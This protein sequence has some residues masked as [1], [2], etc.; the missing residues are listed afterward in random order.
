MERGGQETTHKTKYKERRIYHFFRGRSSFLF[1]YR[2]QNHVLW[3]R[4]YINLLTELQNY[5]RKFHTTGLV[6]NPKVC[7]VS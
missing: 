6:W 4:A 3:V 7:H 2:D 1:P 5:V